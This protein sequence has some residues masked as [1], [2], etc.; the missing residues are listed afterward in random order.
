M[1]LVYKCCCSPRKDY[2]SFLFCIPL[3]LAVLILSLGMGAWGAWEIT[4][5]ATSPLF[6][7]YSTVSLLVFGCLK[8]LFALF[9][10]LGL[11]FCVSPFMH[12]VKLV[13]EILIMIIIIGLIYQWV[14]WGLLLG[15]VIGEDSPDKWVPTSHEQT[16]MI[17]FTVVTVAIVVAGYWV[18]GVIRSLAAVYSAGGHGWQLK[19]YKDISNEKTSKEGVV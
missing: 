18:S 16:Y 9:G 7:N 4:V 14:V 11:V 2:G 19:N 15:G 17:V 13:F 8:C 1:G 12:V 10:L 5:G 6:P 3:A